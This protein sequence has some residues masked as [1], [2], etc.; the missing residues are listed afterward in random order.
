[1][2]SLLVALVLVAGCGT[3]GPTPRPDNV[4]DPLTPEQQAQWLAQQK[5]YT[6]LC[7]RSPL[8]PRRYC[9]ADS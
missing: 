1:V 2:K 4:S 5:F 7:D 6:L 3:S 9:V 8:E